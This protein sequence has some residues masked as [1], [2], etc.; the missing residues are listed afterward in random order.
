[1]QNVYTSTPGEFDTEN[2]VPRKKIIQVS[3]TRLNKFHK[4][5]KNET[6]TKS[7]SHDMKDETEEVFYYQPFIFEGLSKEFII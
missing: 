6:I 2:T 7:F 5:T 1:L 4:Q 3:R